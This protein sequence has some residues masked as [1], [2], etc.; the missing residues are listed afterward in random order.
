[1]KPLYAC[2]EDFFVK[3]P[4]HDGSHTNFQEIALKQFSTDFRSDLHKVTVVSANNNRM[5]GHN[6][7]GFLL[8]LINDVY[9]HS[10]GLQTKPLVGNLSC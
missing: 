7:H 4:Y 8:P 2:A 9:W 6:S 3:L 5:C 1:M 10:P